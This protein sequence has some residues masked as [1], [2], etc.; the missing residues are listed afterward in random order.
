MATLPNRAE[1][2]LTSSNT[3]IGYTLSLVRDD[4]GYAVG[5]ALLFKDLTKSREM[6]NVN[7]SEIDWPRLGRWR[8]SLHTKSR[9]RWPAFR[10]SRAC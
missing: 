4:E 10:C 2:R 7:V 8:R 1:L 9:T 6:Q 5:A 3:A